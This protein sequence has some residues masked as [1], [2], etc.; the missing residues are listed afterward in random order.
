[1]EKRYESLYMESYIKDL[2]K[3]LRIIT[4]L[5]NKYKINFTFIGGAARNQ[6]GYAKI[7]EDVDILVS[8]HDKDKV[9][10]LPIGF[11]R[12]ISDGRGKRFK[13]HN[14]ETLIDIIYSGEISGDGI[15]GLEFKDPKKLSHQIN[16]EPFITLQNLIMYK[17]SSGITGKHRFKDFDDIVEL[18]KRNKL[19]R[20]FADQF[21]ED[22]KNKYIELWDE[23][24]AN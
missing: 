1:M 4:D 24:N 16:N 12:D 18:I 2:K 9:K 17:L 20:D 23:I 6:Y 11:I 5:F 13:L 19:K 21:R 22:L 7:T 8:Q 10:N 3:S 14:P 15:N